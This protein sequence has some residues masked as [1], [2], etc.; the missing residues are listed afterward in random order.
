MCAFQI[1]NSAENVCASG[2][3]YLIA[4]AFLFAYVRPCLS[5]RS[6]EC[7]QASFFTVV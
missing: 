2:L 7:V 3:V 5:M 1:L 4:L 6:Y